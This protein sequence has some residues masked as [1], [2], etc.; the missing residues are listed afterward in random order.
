LTLKQISLDTSSRF[1]ALVIG[2]SGIGKTSLLRTIPT[3]E[4]VC[5]VSA[6]AG[7]LC[8]RDLVE[9]KRVQGFEV[10][11]FAELGEVYQFLTSPQAS[12]FKW[13]FVDSLT[14]IAARCAEAM[15]AKYPDRKDSYPMWGE[16]S[17]KMTLLIKA[18]RE[19][20]NFNV[21]FSCLDSR[22]KDDL[23][24][25]YVGPSIPG[26]SLKE[27]L[28]SWFDEVFYMVSLP[29]TDGKERRAF[30]T[31]PWERFPAKDRSGKLALI[32]APHLGQIKKKIL[33][34]TNYGKP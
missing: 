12:G 7:L 24:R 34:G 3:D 4:P 8:V 28:A 14:E 10:S 5:V 26:N 23:N 33:G 11:T 9:S 6:E 15:K 21:V 17:D 16:F 18:Y 25:Q 2:Q 30:I 32:E 13:I 27:R 29:G 20:S 19:L 1:I 31:Q 22:E